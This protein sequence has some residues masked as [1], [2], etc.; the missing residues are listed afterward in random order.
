MTYYRETIP[1]ALEHL[2]QESARGQQEKIAAQI[3]KLQTHGFDIS[4]EKFFNYRESQYP[5]KNKAGYNALHLAQYIFLSSENKNLVQKIFWK[6][7]SHIAFLQEC[8]LSSGKYAHIGTQQVGEYEPTLEKVANAI[9]GGVLAIPHPN[10]TFRTR[11]NFQEAAELLIKKYPI[12]A[13]EINARADQQRVET[14]VE[15]C[16]KHSLIITF[17]SDF[18]K[19][20]GD[21][22]HGTFGETNPFV[23]PEIL[24]EHYENFLKRI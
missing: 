24:T 14:I 15:F 17:G 2:L 11:E 5:W 12:S 18:H 4:Q 22:T 20:P 7:V 8:L 21:E 16:K 6:E 9:Q 13:I 3:D 19:D 23:P 10:H 1:A